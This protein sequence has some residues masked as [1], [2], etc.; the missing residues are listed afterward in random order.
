MIIPQAYLLAKFSK[1]NKLFFS[2]SLA[3]FIEILLLP[4]INPL[5]MFLIRHNHAY[6]PEYA[7]WID[8]NIAKNAVIITGDEGGFIGYY[9]KRVDFQKPCSLVLSAS[10]LAGFKRKVDG[11]LD[12]NIPVYL[13][14]LGWGSYDY[15]GQFRD[16]V[17]KNYTISTIVSLPF[18]SWHRSPFLN[19]VFEC[20]LIEVK[21]KDQT[22]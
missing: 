14:C 19:E 16:F 22:E 18:E 1:I 21:R 8:H 11:L 20:K 9:G 7:E 13:T 17:D 2:V 12:Q 5:R 4:L 15:N 10:E 3:I 6:I